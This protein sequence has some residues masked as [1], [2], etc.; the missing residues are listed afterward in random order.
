MSRRYKECAAFKKGK[1]KGKRREASN[2]RIALFYYLF[3]SPYP[4]SSFSIPADS[5]RN[6]SPRPAS[7]FSV[8]GAFSP[9]QLPQCSGHSTGLA[10]T[11][12]NFPLASPLIRLA[13]PPVCQMELP[14]VSLIPHCISSSSDWRPATLFVPASRC[15][16]KWQEPIGFLR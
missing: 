12:V 5:R 1:G 16:G 2:R 10:S 15:L 13:L 8:T 7:P 3:I 9:G 11:S 4:S 6:P 14:D